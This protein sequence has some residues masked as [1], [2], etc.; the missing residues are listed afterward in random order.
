[1]VQQRAGRIDPRALL[2]LSNGKDMGAIGGKA[3]SGLTRLAG[4][5]LCAAV[6][7]T[8]F[9]GFVVKANDDAG[10]LAFIRAQTRP[11]PAPVAYAPPRPAYPVSYYAPRSF[12]PTSQ[13]GT[14]RAQPAAVASPAQNARTSPIVA[15][16]APF[17]GLFPAD[18]TIGEPKHKQR[19]SARSATPSTK[20]TLAAPFGR[21]SEGNGARGNRVT[22]C[23]RTCDGFFFPLSNST[24]SDRGDEAACNRLCPTS[25]TKLFIGQVGA[26]MD[27]ARSR[28]NGRRYAQTANAFAYRT[29][30]DKSCSCNASGAGLTT[31]ASVFRDQTLKVGDVVMTQKGMRV[32]IGGQFPYRDANFTTIDRS[33]QIAGG[34]REALR[35]LEQ[36]S[37]PGRSGVTQRAP[38][39][40]TDEL[41]D[42]RRAA[43]AL[44][45]PEQV[46]RYVGPDRNATA[47]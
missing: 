26:D 11:R 2:R 8:A 15:A 39:R 28:Q 13:V 42:L 36:A 30:F 6:G 34:S 44:R 27:D 37:M 16:Y 9:G 18:S 23:V 29:S 38:Q 17:A 43:E 31:D 25:E 14:R 4:I 32:F 20:P 3:L 22:Y 12:F 5:G 47:R 10:A 40:R 35:A 7:L 21:S 19:I 1:M 46:V 33:R 45:T 41:S 24:G